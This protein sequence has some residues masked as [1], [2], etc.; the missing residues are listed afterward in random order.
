MT[1]FFE[2]IQ[3]ATFSIGNA[4]FPVL[5]AVAVLFFYLVW[6]GYVIYASSHYHSPKNLVRLVDQLRMQWMMK[7][8]ERENR[9]IDATL[10]GNLLRS[11]AFFANTTI[12][13]LIG[14]ITALGYRDSAVKL[15]DAIPYAV[16]SSPFM[17]EIKVFNLIVIFIYAFFKFTWSL[18]QYNYCCIL[19]GAAPDLNSGDERRTTYA[20][21]S[22]HLIANAGRHFNMGLRAYYFGLAALS[23][24]VHPL[25]FIA[26]S[27]M[28]VIVLHRREFKSHTVNN[29]SGII[30]E[31]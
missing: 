20:N 18:R 5:D 13:L 4:Q 11:I 22:G 17:W 6:I 19:I 30:D 16:P 7:V 2:T 12:F 21:K 25:L 23:W 3:S 24:F 29:L 31:I 15:I 10:V 28:V 26:I 27:T 14:L 1:I 8:V 9:I